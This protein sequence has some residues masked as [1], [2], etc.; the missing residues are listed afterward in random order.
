MH[1]EQAVQVI[2]AGVSRR[3]Q[4]GASSLARNQQPIRKVLLA[5]VT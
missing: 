5:L 3:K 1:G 4:F 2:A